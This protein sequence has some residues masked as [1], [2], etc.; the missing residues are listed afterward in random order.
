MDMPTEGLLANK[1]IQDRVRKDVPTCGLNQKLAEVRTA[2]PHDWDICV[3]IDPN[4]IVLGL[5]DR[6]GIKDAEGTVDEFMKP[7]PVTLRPGG[8]IEEVAMF[9]DQSKQRFALITK[10]DGQ[11]IGII[12]KTDLEA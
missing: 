4:R 9:L 3:V 7:A 12:R 11:L 6:T 8:L 1:T 5:L 2:M 10:S